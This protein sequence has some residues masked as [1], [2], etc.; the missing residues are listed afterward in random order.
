[1][2]RTESELVTIV[3][4]LGRRGADA[5][6]GAVS[7]AGFGV[8]LVDVEVAHA[9][10]PEAVVTLLADLLSEVNGPD[11]AIGRVGIAQ[12]AIVVPATDPA[13]LQQLARR[14]RLVIGQTS[15]AADAVVVARGGPDPRFGSV[16]W[17]ARVELDRERRRPLQDRVHQLEAALGLSPGAEAE[18]AT[19]SRQLDAALDAAHRDGLTGL[20]NRVGSELLLTSTPMPYALAFVDLDDLRGFNSSEGLYEAGDDAI[21][22]VARAIAAADPSAVA[23][24]WGG[25]EFVVA[26]PGISA[27]DLG[28]RLTHAL[29]RVSHEPPIAGRTV[30]FS[31]GVVEVRDRSGLD[32]AQVRAQAL[33]QH[34]EHT[35][36]KPAVLCE[37]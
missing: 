30:S 18:I 2:L 12:M 26:V 28:E 35:G 3:E 19:L 9:H 4:Q 15:V 22:R 37:D 10:E 27:G 33:L 7:V 6:R 5:Q 23:G 17:A 16:L 29:D 36:L 13:A 8:V 20:R 21:R 24:R 34:I 31:A 1:M 32:D 14:L 25:D 11:V